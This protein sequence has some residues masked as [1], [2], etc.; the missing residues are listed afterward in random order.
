MFVYFIVHYFWCT[1]RK[2]WN[3]KVPKMLELNSAFFLKKSNL[4]FEKR[5]TYY[6][7][8][9][10]IDVA[11][12]TPS[13]GIVQFAFKISNCFWKF[14]QFSSISSV[15]SEEFIAFRDRLTHHAK[16]I[17]FQIVQKCDRLL[18][19]HRYFGHFWKT[20]SIL[21]AFRYIPPPRLFGLQRSGHCWKRAWREN[22]VSGR[23]WRSKLIWIWINV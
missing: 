22:K 12:V 7:V 5:Q 4:Q 16:T 23:W 18:F 11:I 1:F 10:Q 17:C 13:M 19:R 9:Q 15:L 14:R 3:F 21:K 20:V 6:S 2:C 8:E